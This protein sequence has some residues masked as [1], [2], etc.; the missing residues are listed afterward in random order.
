MTQIP[1]LTSLPPSMKRVDQR[2]VDVGAA[3]QRRCI[4]SWRQSGFAP[5]SLNSRAEP[6]PDEQQELVSVELQDIDATSTFGRPLVYLSSF[7]ARAR[8]E[9]SRPVAITNAD[10][11][12]CLTPEEQQTVRDLRPG[13]FL[14]AHRTDVDDPWLRSQ[15]RRFTEGYDLF[16]FHPQDLARLDWM[17]EE[18]YVF[19]M[20]WWDYFLPVALVL[21]GVRSRLLDSSGVVH[22]RH[23]NRWHPYAGRRFG[24]DFLSD[25]KAFREHCQPGT[26]L[27]SE[28]LEFLETLE[29]PAPPSLSST[30]KGLARRVL[31]GETDFETNHALAR[32]ARTTRR[33]LVNSRGLPSLLPTSIAE[34]QRST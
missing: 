22:M 10:I 3:Y 2:K 26:T 20:P 25:M 16:V 15:P 28:A 19:G 5:I 7:L 13:E 1:L 9:E 4:E 34:S 33:F 31:L 23:A 11:C 8:K 30:L 24:E 32:V 21:S 14:L 29:K 6:L 27:T 12:L 18:S 17:R